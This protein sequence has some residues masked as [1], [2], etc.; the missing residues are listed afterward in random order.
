K[1]VSP[2]VDQKG[3]LVD[4]GKLRFD[5]SQ[6]SA[7]T[8][9]ELKQVEA[10]V[11]ETI[12]EGLEIYTHAAPIKA[13]REIYGLRAVFG[14]TYPDPVRVVSIGAPVQSVLENPSNKAWGNLSIEFCGGTHLANTNEAE[15]FVIVEESALSTGVR[16][17]VGFTKDAAANARL[18]GMELCSKVDE[19]ETMDMK[20][21]PDVVPAVANEVNEAVMSTIEKQE[22]RERLGK[23]QKKC[24][25]AMKARAKGA[26]EE[27]VA[28]AEREIEKIK[29]AGGKMA[30]IVVPLEGDGKALSKLTS[31]FVGDWKDGSVM[32]VSVDH[33]KNVIRCC[34]SSSTVK[35]NEWMTHT[36]KAVGGRGGGK[37][38]LANGTA[39]YSGEEQVQTLVSCAKQFGA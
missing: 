9:Q 22:I 15:D 24:S 34:A 29:E 10:M 27:G 13:A 4:A 5:F 2:T 36:M 8:L 37:A 1:V 21:L 33:K 3:S 16:R 6:K 31:K 14:E 18:L 26:M 39:P 30:V 23:L 17:I 7:L 28:A 20:K 12:N 11:R 25:E 35:A 19:C 32:A 38:T